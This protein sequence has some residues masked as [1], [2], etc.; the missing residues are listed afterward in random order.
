SGGN[1]DPASGGAG[2]DGNSGGA[3]PLSGGSPGA[4]GD[5]TGIPGSGG[6]DPGAPEPELVTSG[7]GAY[8][9]V[10]E[11][12]PGGAAATV[13][14]TSSATKQAWHGFG[15]TFNEKGWTALLA[16]S[17]ADR[18]AAISLLFDAKGGIGF[19]WGRI[20]IGPS[21]YAN[22]RYTLSSGPDNFSIAHDEQT[23]MPYIKAAQAVKNDIKF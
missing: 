1:G 8:W 21:D 6:S 19:T 9:Q 17:E 4:G 10:G 14:V 23:L 2:V 18:A 11:L 20:P 13:T 12:T 15:G 5:G 7:P 22:E 16:L 3:G